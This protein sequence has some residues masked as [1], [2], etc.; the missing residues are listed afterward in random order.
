MRSP[1]TESVK[2]DTAAPAQQQHARETLRVPERLTSDKNILTLTRLSMLHTYLGRFADRN[3][4]VPSRLS[5]LQAVAPEAYNRVSIDAWGNPI[6]Y[7]ANV[8][9]YELR[10]FG[11]D[12]VPATSD[13]LVLVGIPS[14]EQPCYIVRGDARQV[15]Y[16]PPCWGMP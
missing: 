4:T 12:A 15:Q 9:R 1:R 14:R 11:A 10:S 6:H 16:S 13:D 3:G 2:V 5:D 7:E 8:T